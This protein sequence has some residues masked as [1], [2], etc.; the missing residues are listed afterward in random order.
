MDS[1]P[2]LDALCIALCGAFERVN[3]Q[4]HGISVPPDPG[5]LHGISRAAFHHCLH[6]R[7]DELELTWHCYL[8]RAGFGF[9]LRAGPPPL[10]RRL[11][12]RHLRVELRLRIVVDGYR[13][14]F[15]RSTAGWRRRPKNPLQFVLAPA[16]LAQVQALQAPRK[17]SLLRRCLQRLTEIVTR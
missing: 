13:M 11:L 7:L 17:Q 14:S 3:R 8:Q 6:P 12:R 9:V 10:W 16:Q 5:T 1:P 15:C 4:L 2:S